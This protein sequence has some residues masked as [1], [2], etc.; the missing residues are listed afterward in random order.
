MSIIDSSIKPKNVTL[1]NG[2]TISNSIKK[3]DGGSLFLN[4]AGKSGSFGN[5]GP[6]ALVSN[7]TDFGFGKGDFTIEMWVYA[8]DN[9]DWRTLIS[10]GTYNGGLLW[11]MGTSN[12]QLYMTG[13]GYEGLNALSTNYWNWGASSV[14][15]NQWSHL[16]LVRYNG[17]VKTYINGAQ[18]FSVSGGAAAS[19]LGSS[20]SVY[21]GTG[22]HNIGNEIFN[23][24][25]DE[26]RITKGIGG[27]RYPSNFDIDLVSSSAFPATGTQ[28]SVPQV[29]TGLNS[30][31]INSGIHLG[32]TP[33]A[34]D[35]GGIITD[36]VIEYSTDGTNWIPF[37][38][39]AITGRTATITG[40]INGTPYSTRVA[41]INIAGTGDYVT[42]SNIVPQTGLFKEASAEWTVSLGTGSPTDKYFKAD[43]LSSENAGPTIKSSYSGV[44]H[45]TATRA[46]SDTSIDIY[47]NTTKVYEYGVNTSSIDNFSLIEYPSTENYPNGQ[48]IIKP[49]IIP[50]NATIKIGSDG[51]Y[52]GFDNFTMWITLTE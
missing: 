48:P 13:V 31:P 19:D 36:H 41:P 23:G 7:N 44:L 5:T 6:Y 2:A 29:I 21:I 25:I 37:N 16:A 14:P 52:T 26:L 27:A 11:R 24:Y 3:F 39:T 33:P 1:N 9:T 35:N 8:L 4:G 18:S 15:L 12:A 51:D 47:V 49:V 22:A 42:K 40:L 20:R 45:I 32:W 43:F 46:Y 34:E 30:I 10:I 50:A 38:H 28:I 17:T